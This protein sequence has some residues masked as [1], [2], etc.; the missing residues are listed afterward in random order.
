MHNFVEISIDEY[1]KD[2]GIY[3]PL[4]VDDKYFTCFKCSVCLAKFEQN[5]NYSSAGKYGYGKYHD[6]EFMTCDEVIIKQI[7]E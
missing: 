3:T 6:Y 2:I 1:N 5:S 4:S 7:I